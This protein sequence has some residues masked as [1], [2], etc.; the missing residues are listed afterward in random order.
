MRIKD[1][2]VAKNRFLAEVTFKDFLFSCEDV[3]LKDKTAMTKDEKFQHKR[4]FE[5]N[6]AY[7]KETGVW[8]LMYIDEEGM[9]CSLCRLRNTIHPTDICKIWNC[10][11]N[12]QYRTENVKDLFKNNTGTQTVHKVA[13]TKQL[14]K[15][16]IKKDESLLYSSKR[17]V[18]SDLYWFCKQEIAHFKLFFC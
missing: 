18:F 10:D 16:E 13:V 9:F 8:C 3:C 1:Y 4:I 12:T 7:C 5:A 2:F 6:L 17:K 11:P 14:A 15:Y